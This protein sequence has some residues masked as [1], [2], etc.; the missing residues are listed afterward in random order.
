MYASVF[1]D[2]GYNYFIYDHR[3]H[4]EIQAAG[5]EPVIRREF[6]EKVFQRAEGQHEHQRDDGGGH[7]GRREQ[8]IDG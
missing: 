4:G 6:G 3:H 5:G 7:G 1:D 8:G 2:L